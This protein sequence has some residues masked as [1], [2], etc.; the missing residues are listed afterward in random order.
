MLVSFDQ[1][2]EDATDDDHHEWR[3][4]RH[5]EQVWLFLSLKFVEF[6]RTPKGRVKEQY[7]NT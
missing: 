2:S 1:E 5:P 4:G 3:N 6:V 7:C